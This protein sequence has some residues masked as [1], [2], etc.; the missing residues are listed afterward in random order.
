M[1]RESGLISRAQKQ[2]MGNSNAAARGAG[3]PG[4]ALAARQTATAR[5]YYIYALVSVVIGG[6][7]IKQVL[8]AAV[9]PL[10]GGMDFVL[11]LLR[12]FL[13]SSDRRLCGRPNRFG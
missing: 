10:H 2:R 12:Y 7:E 11:L 3:G 1:R 13:N 5:P 8:A 4:I 6:G 9:E